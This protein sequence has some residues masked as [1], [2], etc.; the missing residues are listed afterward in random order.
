VILVDTSVWIDHLR[1]T[2][3]RLATLLTNNSVLAHPFVIG[4]LALDTLRDPENVLG[5]L[6]KLPQAMKAEDA[7]VLQLIRT[8]NLAGL[9]IGYVDSHLLASTLLTPGASFWTYDKRLAAVA[10]RL[11]LAPLVE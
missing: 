6:G 8:R 10:S 1:S 9:G 3:Q 7:E 2:N 11:A 4:E 5:S